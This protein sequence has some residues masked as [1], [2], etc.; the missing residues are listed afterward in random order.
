MSWTSDPELQQMFVTELEERCARLLEGARAMQAGAI[1]D[2]LAGVMLR[3]G[4]T[5]KGTSRVM[6]F[7]ALSRAGQLLEQ[8]WRRVQHGDTKASVSIGKALEVV[9]QAIPAAAVADPATGTPELIDAIGRLDAATRDVPAPVAEKAPAPLAPVA[10]EPHNVAVLEHAPP[11]VAAAPPAHQEAAH[12]PVSAEVI[13]L[14][15]EA[16]TGSRITDGS[17]NRQELG[18][19]LGALE[20]WAEVQTMAVNAGR[21]YRLINQ[22][23]DLRNEIASV[24]A[25]DVGVAAGSGTMADLA[26][27]MADLQHEALDLAAVPLTGMTNSLPQLVRYLAKKLDKDVRFE[28]VGDEGIAA[29]RQVIDLISDPVR[30]II[31]NSLRHGV[32]A[33]S[34]RKRVGKP[35]TGSVAVT[36]AVKD[37]R[38]E[39]VVTDDGAGI[40]WE[41][42]RAEAIERGMYPSYEGVD[43]ER[44]RGVLFADGFSTV[45]PNELGGHGAGLSTVAHAVETLYGR[46]KL[47]SKAGVG[48]TVT[49]TVPTSRALQRVVTLE[50][51]DM[52]WAIPEAVVDEVI[53]TQGASII[54]GAHGRVLEWHDRTVPMVALE[55]LIGTGGDADPSQILIV[56][57]R[58]GEVAIAVEAVGDVREVAVK[59]LGP[60]LSGPSHITGAALLGGGDVVLVLDAARFFEREADGTSEATDAGGRVLVVDDSSGARAVVSGALTSSGFSTSVASSVAEALD[61][62]QTEG[63]DAIVVDFSMPQEDGIAL[64]DQVRR[65][66]ADLPVVMLSGVATAEDQ[67]RAQR[68]GV[69]AF[70]EKADFREGALAQTLR[71]ILGARGRAV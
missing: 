31:V 9:A 14:R 15:P 21:L 62:L 17:V 46:I 26:K 39:I 44:L 58:L 59:E 57:H 66:Y 55:D 18:G 70:F 33:A 64:I 34:V 25:P 22:I 43:V 68:A 67:D 11:E 63:A 13:P 20:S 54:G 8:L 16:A 6:G 5:I 37:G 1:D 36:V 71:E 40:D 30:Q 7:E 41:A 19:L 50:H 45:T 61:I 56:S 12:D 48:T 24:E 32:E 53:P 49:L 2:E 47:E 42:V 4:H 10:A 60:L 38:L 65:H 69:D 23:A 29:D 51:G 27:S 52:R 35:T 3:E 28:V